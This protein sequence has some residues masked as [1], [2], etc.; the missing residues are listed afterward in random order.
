LAKLLGSLGLNKELAQLVYLAKIAQAEDDMSRLEPYGISKIELE[1]FGLS[2]GVISKLKELGITL[3]SY[4][5]SGQFGNVFSGVYSGKPV[6]IKIAIGS[7]TGINN[8]VEN[9]NEIKDKID[10]FPDFVKVLFPKIF[11]A[12]KDKDNNGN[13][14]QI[15]V[16]EK[17]RSIPKELSSIVNGHSWSMAAEDFL[18]K[19]YPDIKSTADALNLSFPPLRKILPLAKDN[20]IG[21]NLGRFLSKRLMS[22][23]PT[24]EIE[25]EE[26]EPPEE[27]YNDMYNELIQKIAKFSEDLEYVYSEPM[28]TYGGRQFGGNERL[29]DAHGGLENFW[30]GISWLRDAG[31]SVSDLHSNNIMMDDAGNLKISDLGGLNY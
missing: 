14:F 1:Y 2:S 7:A 20:R 18:E 31:Y 9:W 6:V 22:L 8:D 23:I 16:V 3:L 29:W 21:L 17:L 27:G 24:E 15:L 4:I 19:A 5:S 10:S 11:L 28:P 30:K 12:Y 13:D 25:Y 26:G